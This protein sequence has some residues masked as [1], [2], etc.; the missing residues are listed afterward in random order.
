MEKVS[1]N[2][3]FDCNP[4]KLNVLQ[5]FKLSMPSFVG[6]VCLFE[7]FSNHRTSCDSLSHSS[8]SKNSELF[9]APFSEMSVQ[10]L[11]SQ[12][13][14][15]TSISKLFLCRMDYLNLV[16]F[17]LVHQKTSRFDEFVSRRSFTPVLKQACPNEGR[18]FCR[19]LL[20]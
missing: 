6:V 8:H 5:K 7:I 10:M 9:A 3:C 13:P 4:E 20:G 1:T 14:L 12:S 17:N 19:V 11:P 15:P 2:H 18:K 16:F